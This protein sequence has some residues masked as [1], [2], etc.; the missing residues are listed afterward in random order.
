[1]FPPIGFFCSG[2]TSDRAR[3]SVRAREESV[4]CSGGCDAHV[5]SHPASV[6]CCYD[7]VCDNDRDSVLMW[8]YRVGLSV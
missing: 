2:E 7:L 8:A 5:G 4:G 6:D 1:M 3:Q